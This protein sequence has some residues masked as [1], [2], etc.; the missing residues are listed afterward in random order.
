[1]ICNDSMR[2]EGIRGRDGEGRAEITESASQ[3]ADDGSFRLF[4]FR[5]LPMR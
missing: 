1:M 4:G 5:T 2:Q 3:G